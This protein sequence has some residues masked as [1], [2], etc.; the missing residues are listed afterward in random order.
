VR[1]ASANTSASTAMAVRLSGEVN[2]DGNWYEL[3][4]DAIK[5]FLSKK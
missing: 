5:T 1:G 3:G 2:I 4:G